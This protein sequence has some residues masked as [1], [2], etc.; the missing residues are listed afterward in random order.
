[1]GCSK[2]TLLHYWMPIFLADVYSFI[3]SLEKLIDFGYFYSASIP[4]QNTRIK[5][6]LN[7]QYIIH[8]SG[9]I[10]AEHVNKGSFILALYSVALTNNI[11]ARCVNRSKVC[12]HYKL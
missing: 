12:V 2:K 11:H 4:L 1:M 5:V 7:V 3:V 8:F 6:V 10:L 9:I